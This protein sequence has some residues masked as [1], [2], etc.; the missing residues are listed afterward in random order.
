MVLG[1]N[2]KCFLICLVLERSTLE[3]HGPHTCYST[4]VNSYK[5]VLKRG[6][7]ELFMCR[8]LARIAFSRWTIRSCIPFLL[9]QWMILPPWKLQLWFYTGDVV[10]WL[11]WLLSW[12]VARS[13]CCSFDDS[14]PISIWIWGGWDD[15]ERTERRQ[16]GQ[17]VCLDS[18]WSMQSRW[19]TCPHGGIFWSLSSVLYSPKQTEH[20]QQQTNTC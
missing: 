3:G 6:W 14:S 5:S 16:S 4:W 9:Q 17:V 12:G 8:Y 10:S 15:G 19:N 13:C 2:I 11:A 18:Q 20:L 1:K 7:S